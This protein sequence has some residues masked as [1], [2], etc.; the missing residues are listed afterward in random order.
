MDRSMNFFL[1]FQLLC[2]V[3]FLSQSLILHALFLFSCYA[4]IPS[5]VYVICITSRSTLSFGVWPLTQ[6]SY[7]S[8]QWTLSWRHKLPSSVHHGGPRSS[9]TLTVIW[10]PSWCT[11]AW[12]ELLYCS[13]GSSGNLRTSSAANSVWPPWW[14]SLFLLCS[15][16]SFCSS[17]CWTRVHTGHSV[18]GS[19]NA[20]VLTPS[21]NPSLNSTSQIDLPAKLDLKEHRLIHGLLKQMINPE[22]AAFGFTHFLSAHSQGSLICW[23]T[24]NVF[25][26]WFCKSRVE[27]SQHSCLN[28]VEDRVP[29]CCW[30]K[31]MLNEEEPSKK[32]AINFWR[33]IRDF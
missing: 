6:S 19:H 11:P 2:S 13:W 30:N 26:W 22:M 29:I 23:M 10:S 12:L 1:L 27:I 8:I 14:F 31:A 4:R 17:R 18:V 9:R 7:R 28:K 21:Y 5:T 16:L 32:H 20:L 25:F 33:K 24:H 15:L 3:P